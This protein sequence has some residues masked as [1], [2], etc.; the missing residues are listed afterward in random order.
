M[1]K[2]VVSNIVSLDGYFEGPDRNVMALNMD[3]AFDAYNLERIRS[4][5]T[6]L[7]GRTSYDGFS[8]YWPDI[9]GAAPDPADRALSDDNRELSRIYNRL[10][11]VVVTERDVP[12]ADN[13]W[14]DTTT[15]VRRD[16]VADWLAEE[17]ARDSGDILTFGS[18]TMWNGLLEKGLIDE[19][20]LMVGPSALGDGTPIFRV[21]ADLTLLATRR[22]EGS[23]N[24]LLRYAADRR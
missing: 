21:P 6:V 19:L 2:V 14:H 23:D 18:R 4:A 15:V 3:E 22:F 11:K 20:H 24:V 12:A 10:E 7:L 16:A 5:G 13:P 17:R 1:R 9:A 8:S